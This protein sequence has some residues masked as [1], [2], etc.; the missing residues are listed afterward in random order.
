MFTRSA[1]EMRL[2]VFAVLALL[3]TTSKPA[4][5]QGLSGQI[6]GHVNDPSGSSVVG[7]TVQLTNEL[8]KQV[9]EAQTDSTG[10]FVFVELLPGD[11]S[12]GVTQAG[13]RPY[14]QKSIEVSANERVALRPIQLQLGDITSTVTVQAEA[15]RVQTD[16]SE[17][18]GLI[19]TAQMEN[20]PQRGRDYM[21]ELK[22]L[23]GVI[24]LVTRDAPGGT[25]PLVNGGLTGQVVISLDGIV[26]QNTGAL[27][28]THYQPTVDAISEMKVL[29]NNY[30]AEYGERSGGMV[31]VIIKS[32]TREFHGSAYYFKRNEALNANNFFNNANRVNVGADG[33]ARRPVYRYDNFGYTIGGPLIVPGTRFNKS[34]NK[35]FFFW[36]HDLLKNKNPTSLQ[37][38][39]FPTQ[40][41]RQGD[42]SQSVFGNNGQHVVVRDPTTQA[43][44]P[45]DVVPASQ[46]NAA[47]Q[48]IL[49]LFPL[50]NA[51]DP[52]GNRQYNALYQFVQDQP[53]SNKIL[54]VDYNV[55]PQTLFYAR[56]LN[57]YQNSVGYG[58]SLGGAT[59]W[60][61]VQTG[62][63]TQTA[64][65]VGTVVHTFSSSLVT[66]FTWGINRSFENTSYNTDDLKPYTRAGAGLGG[67]LLPELYPQANLLNLLPNALFGAGSGGGIINNS[68]S[69]S[70]ES[71]FPYFGTDTLQNVTESVSWI[72]GKH[73][74][75]FGVYYEHDSRNSPYSGTFDWGNLNFGSTTL[76]PLDTGW[77]YS[78][79]ILGVAQQ[80]NESNLKPVRNSRYTG[81][82]WFVQDSWR[83]TRKLTL[84]LGI[85]FQWTPPSSSAGVKMASF[86]SSL[87]N[88]SLNP[89]L[90]QPTCLTSARPCSGTT[91]ANPLMGLNTVTGQLVPSALIGAFTPNAGTP[92]QAMHLYN[93][94]LEHNPPLGI[95]PRFG[96]AYDIFGDGKMAIRGG[97]GVFYDRTGGAG[98]LGSDSCCIYV[99]DPPV[100]LTPSIYYTTVPQL[101]A[102]PAYLTPQNVDSAQLTYKLPQ[103]FNWSVGVQRS[104]GLGMVL[105]V[106][107][108]A[109]TTRHV[110]NLL[111]ENQIPYGT[112]RLATGQLNPATI[113][114]T[115][116]QP[117]Q[118]NFLRPLLGYGSISYGQFS[119]SSN[120][121]SAQTQLHRRFG[122]R[123]LFGGS[124]TWSKL[125]SYAPT[126]FL[127]SGFTYSPDANDHRHNVTANWTYQV[128]DGSFFWKNAVTKQVLDGWQFTGIAGFL[129]GGPATVS[130]G[131]TGAPAGYTI[132][133]SPDALATRIQI[134]GDPTRPQSERTDET[135]SAL[136]PAAFALPAQPA[137]GIGNSARN[138]FYGPGIENFDLTLFK[139]FGLGKEN[140]FLQIRA[141]MYNALNHVNFNNPNASATFN[142]TT[143]AQTNTNFGRYTSARD[144]RY[145]VLAARIRF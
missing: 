96:F 130:Y 54:R 120:Y 13:F 82:E 69:I 45:G 65:A 9:R 122:K 63:S 47:G 123:L 67:N 58:E 55:A 118:A 18:S 22:V 19:N 103:T 84:D 5:G 23:P 20:I 50:P 68:A 15:A 136:N 97:F 66:E 101:L 21:G 12:I 132:T 4:A 91:G 109:N 29:L 73:N 87:Y 78:N 112:T 62:S 51:V 141:E 85:R 52:T 38:V 110:Y 17:R 33:K 99:I 106:A 56:L 28:G 32:G 74:M 107:Y 24:D 79:A 31:N 30:Q 115:T 10:S 108:V 142:Y 100:V 39:T 40:L 6:S 53:R 76:N 11:Y 42:F 75:K 102:A 145:I 126:P 94:T 81:F 93:S 114:P 2:A 92:F 48:A 127:S 14:A 86:D 70:F 89:P 61:Q 124:W 34:R 98:S 134:V 36:S 49:K 104:V 64:G 140:R 83:V 26:S 128:P 138:F 35:L 1:F 43:P 57:G 119:N 77:G 117:Y 16:S 113:D 131:I 90:I 116:N 80:Y 111:N 95:G 125:M 8:T 133:G 71:R 144:P 7:C 139:D 41:E 135:I 105:D 44:I 121:N 37:Q 60:P 88:P 137:F 143:G 27:T 59:N 25:T 46:I 72:K 129:S 3:L